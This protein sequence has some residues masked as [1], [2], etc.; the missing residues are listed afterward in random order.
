MN[1]EKFVEYLRG[2]S[3]KSWSVNKRSNGDREVRTASTDVRCENP[4]KWERLSERRFQGDNL[5]GLAR[6]YEIRYW[7]MNQVTLDGI[8]SPIALYA[9]LSLSLFLSP[10][11]FIRF[12]RER[13]REE[14]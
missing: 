14:G 2:I 11:T 10:L 12:R 13:G 9:A 3:L 7:I 6:I 1:E 5:F 4:W 8:N